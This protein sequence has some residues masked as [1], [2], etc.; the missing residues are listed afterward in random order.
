MSAYVA[1][2]NKVVNSID[3]KKIKSYHQK[4]RILWEYTKDD[5]IIKKV[6]T[7]LELKKDFRQ[8]LLHM[9]EQEITYISYGHWV[10]FWERDQK[11]LGDLRAIFRLADFT[12]EQ[13]K[14]NILM[15]EEMLCSAIEAE[16]YEKAALIRDELKNINMNN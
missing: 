2:I 13:E 14:G 8:I 5:V 10:I 3:W 11:D 7:V 12:H 1:Y 9:I 6:P 15:L 4:L 16:D